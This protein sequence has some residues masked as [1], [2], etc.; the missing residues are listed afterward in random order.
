MTR[1]PRSW[2]TSP[3][4]RTTAASTR[5]WATAD[6]GGSANRDG[7]RVR[8]EEFGFL[9]GFALLFAPQECKQPA[10]GSVVRNRN[11]FPI[12]ARRLVDLG[13]DRVRVVTRQT[14]HVVLPI[15]RDLH[16][17]IP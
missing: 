9:A 1:P 16:S 4:T 10:L 14:S 8:D 7:L 15:H 13:S 5:R 12:L 2:R 17:R 6:A 11:Q 3:V